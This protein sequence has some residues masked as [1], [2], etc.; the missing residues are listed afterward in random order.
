MVSKL[1]L[2]TVCIDCRTDDLT[3]SA[4]FW[5]E[6]LG[7]QL[8][9]SEA[10]ADGDPAR[11]MALRGNTGPPKFLLQKVDHA[12]RMHLDFETDDPSAEVAR[13]VALGGKIVSR[14]KY[15]T[16]MEAPTGHRFCIMASD[17]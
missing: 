13:I 10:G 6:L 4:S 5:S 14:Q 3:Q 8:A 12:P 11:Y 16:V 15:W 17:D 1:R 2:R 9:G 7:L